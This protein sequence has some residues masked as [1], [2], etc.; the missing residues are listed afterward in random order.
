VVFEIFENVYFLNDFVKLLINYSIV[1]LI[2]V[3]SYGFY[4]LYL[5]ISKGVV[6][7]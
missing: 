7:R 4:R 5:K 1:I 6:K 2:G 3:Q